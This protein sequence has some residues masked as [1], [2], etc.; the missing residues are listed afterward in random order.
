MHLLIL[1]CA[2]APGMS[3]APISLTIMESQ[4]YFNTCIMYICGHKHWEPGSAGTLH[5]TWL[6]RHIAWN[7]LALQAHCMEPGSAGTLHGTWL[8]RHIYIQMELLWRYSM[9]TVLSFNNSIF[10]GVATPTSLLSIIQIFISV[11]TPTSLLSIIQ[12]S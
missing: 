6:C 10:I 12:Y 3:T 1:G 8:C 2:S 5:G 11:A 9:V 7:R 4:S